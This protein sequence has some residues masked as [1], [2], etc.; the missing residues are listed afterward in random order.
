MGL[1]DLSRPVDE[2]R[3]TV[4]STEDGARLDHVLAA[5]ITWRSRNDLQRRIREST[6]AVNGR[7]AKAAQRVRLGDVISVRVEAPPGETVKPDSIAIRILHD[8]PLF[9]VLDK[10]AGAVIHP[11]GKYVLD[12][13]MNVL[14]ARYR[15]PDC[16]EKD[17]VPMVVHRLDR[18]TSGVLVVA[19]DETA[20]RRL[21]SAFESR[22][23][24]KEYLA[25]VHGDLAV[26]RMIDLP[27]GV[28]PARTHNTKMACVPDG[29]TSMTRVAR[30]DGSE[31][32]RSSAASGNRTPAPDPRASGRDRPPDPL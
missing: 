15:D 9:L 23:V 12:T 18:D 17:V 24:T 3:H 22:E 5:W 1:R 27:I 13:L 6:V 19:K 21:G 29:R 7:P 2:I 20:R 8:E 26:A 4:V 10:P 14:H 28:D 32:R 11:V 16:A 25:L 30:N 31:L